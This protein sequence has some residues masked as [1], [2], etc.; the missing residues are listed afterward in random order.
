MDERARR[1]VRHGYRR[2]ARSPMRLACDSRL[3]TRLMMPFLE[4]SSADVLGVLQACA[5][6][7]NSDQLRC[8]LSSRTNIR[9]G[10]QTSTRDTR[11]SK[12]CAGRL[13]SPIA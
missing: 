10:H 2:L 1:L 7:S 13:L 3:V 4:M 9:C 12:F 8:Q 5:G 11:N 6:A